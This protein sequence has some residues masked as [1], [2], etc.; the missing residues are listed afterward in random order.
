MKLNT[1]A[2]K[3]AALK[4]PRIFDAPRGGDGDPPQLSQPLYEYA[5]AGLLRDISGQLS[6]KAQGVKL[7]EIG[8]QIVR[9]T[10]TGLLTGWQEG[11]DICPPWP[12]PFPWPPR[13]D[14]FEAMTVT[15][16]DI[17]LAQAVREIA[18]MTFD[19]EFSSALKAVSE[20]IVKVAQAKVFDDFCGT[21]V[22]PRKPPKPKP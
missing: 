18:S 11:D 15:V 1:I 16:R 7:R 2:A 8:Q 22:K 13:I 14:W 17:F 3:I 19:Q 9:K 6:Q 4:D 12:W 5:L 10:A 21:P 20:D